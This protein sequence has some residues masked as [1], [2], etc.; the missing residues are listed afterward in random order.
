M[1]VI[2]AEAV[3]VIK[4]A[5]VETSAPGPVLGLLEAAANA[6][7]PRRRELETRSYTD[8]AESVRNH[9]NWPFRDAVPYG[10][11]LMV[12]RD[13]VQVVRHTFGAHEVDLEFADTPIAI[14]FGDFGGWRVKRLLIAKGWPLRWSGRYHNLTPEQV[15]ALPKPRSRPIGWSLVGLS[16]LLIAMSMSYEL[17][18]QNYKER[19]DYLFIACFLGAF[20]ALGFAMVAIKKGL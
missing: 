14:A 1:V 15:A 19:L 18:P 12:P 17:W 5:V 4:E 10:R 16:F 6:A 13:A 11:V 8:L 3:Y 20:V 9:P 7:L 2:G